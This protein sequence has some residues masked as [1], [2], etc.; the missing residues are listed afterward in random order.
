SHEVDG[1]E[2]CRNKRWRCLQPR[3]LCHLRFREPRTPRPAPR[4]WHGGS[5]ARAAVDNDAAAAE[6]RARSS[7]IGGAYLVIVDDSSR[8]PDLQTEL[9]G[10][11]PT[12]N[13]AINS[14]Q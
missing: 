10:A 1:G 13:L 14:R 7:G 3:G 4:R 9:I 2:V 8:V 5:P 6:D 12:R 11:A